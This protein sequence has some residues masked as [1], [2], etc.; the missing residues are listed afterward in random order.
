MSEKEVYT[1][2]REIRRLSRCGQSTELSERYR[3]FFGRLSPIENVVM[4]TCYLK[5]LSYDACGDRVVY[6]CERQVKRIVKR[7]VRKLITIRKEL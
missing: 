1:E 7:S 4:T 2:L 5:G 6:Y 3:G